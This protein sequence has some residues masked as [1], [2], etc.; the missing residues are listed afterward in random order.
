MLRETNPSQ[1]TADDEVRDRSFGIQHGAAATLAASRADESR[2]GS[3]PG[4]EA[5]RPNAQAEKANSAITLG[6]PAGKRWWLLAA[7]SALLL[8]ALTAA[9]VY[10]VTKKPSTVDQ[11]VILTVPSGA[12]IKLDSRDYGHSPVKLERL[13][14][15]TYTL[16][17]SKDGFETIVQPITVAESGPP[18]EFKLKMVPPSEAVGLPPEEQIRMYQLRAEEAF[19]RGNYGVGLYEG[20]ALYYADF[21]RNVDSNNSFAVEMRERVRNAAHQA[22]QAAIPRGDLAQAQ[23]IYSFLIENYPE[24]DEVRAAAARLENQL[25]AKRGEV[26]DLLRKADEALQA[27]RLID[28]ART[29]AYYYSRQALAIDR[30][31]EK[32]RQ[33]RNQVRETLA[34]AGEQALARG[35]IEAAAKQFEQVGQLF[36]EDK[37]SRNRLR[38]IQAKQAAEPAKGADPDTL[39]LRGLDH[40]VKENFHS[41]IPD[42][43]SALAN[44]RSTTE[45]IFA[46]ARSYMKIGQLDNA[47]SYFRQI[48]PGAGDAYRSSIAALGEI[49]RSRGDTATAVERWKEARQLGGSTLYSVATLDDKIEQVEKKQR[50]KAAEPSP[51]SLEIKHIHGGLLGG[52]CTGTLTINATGVRYD[53]Q[54]GQH[55][56]ASN[57][58]S[59]GVSQSKDEI[60]IKFQGNSQKFRVPRADA[61][62]IRETLSRY[63]QTYSPAK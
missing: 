13:A 46:L 9:G 23:E 35:D 51:L 14:I 26:R 15:G 44:G 42:L 53:G 43:E 11:L 6:S 18:V 56:Y 7:V 33:I 22:A 55:V 19:A 60:V 61:D 24:D 54:G 32:A 17:I 34:S 62:R 48:K 20:S 36:P 25:S 10:L 45:V 39:R 4:V 41:A 31:N 3:V 38:D 59:A 49:A 47:E 27:G 5:S 16:T 28:P 50:E 29:S 21:I 37:Q 63:Q 1:H 12:D 52:T 8:T 58:V 40:Y 57:L 2:V 30:Q